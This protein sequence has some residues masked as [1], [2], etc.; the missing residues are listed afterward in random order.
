MAEIRVF[1][2]EKFLCSALCPELAGATV[3]LREILRSRNRRR[4]ELRGILRNRQSAVDT[5]LELKRGEAAEKP[6]AQIQN[7]EESAVRPAA[8]RLKRYRN[9]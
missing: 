2:N 1:H 5:L 7:E 9:E 3:P 6:N 8:P 4:R